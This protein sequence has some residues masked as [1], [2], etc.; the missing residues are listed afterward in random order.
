[1]RILSTL[2]IKRSVKFF[3]TTILLGF[4]LPG[5][6]YAQATGDFRSLATG[7]WNANTTWQRYSGLAWVAAAVGETP[8][9]SSAVLIRDGHTVTVST[10]TGF[11]CGNLTVGEGTSGILSIGGF[12]MT[13]TGT[14][15]IA[16]GGRINVTSATGT[17]K[18]FTGNFTNNGIWN[19]SGNSTITFTG[20]ITN[21]GTFT[22][23]SGAYSLSGL[24]K[25]INSTNA[26]GLTIPSITW[27][28]SYTISSGFTVA[29][30]FASTGITMSNAASS[31]TNNGVVTVSTLTLSNAAAAV[32]NAGTLTP[33]TLTI[34]SAGATVTNTGTVTCGTM[35][36]SATGVFNNN[37]GGTLNYSGSTIT[38]ILNASTNANL[39][40]YTA[41]GTQTVKGTTYHNLTI[42]GSG[43]KTLGAATQ[44][45]K[46]LIVSGTA[47]LADGAFAITGNATGTFQLGSG[48]GYTTTRTA[49]NWFVTNTPLANYTIDNNSTVTF[50]ASSTFTLVNNIPSTY[51]HLIFSG[52]GTKTL[53]ASFPITV[54]GNLTITTG[55]MAD[56]GNTITV[57]GNIASTGNQQGAGKVLLTGGAAAHGMQ[58]SGWNNVELDDAQGATLTAALTIGTQTTGTFALTNGVV[59]MNNFNFTINNVN[60]AGFS[61]GSSVAAMV[62]HN[63]TGNFIRQITN[64]TFPTTYLFPLGE[65]LTEYS[66]VSVTINSNTTI[67]NMAFRVVDAQHP[68]DV[69]TTN[70]ASRY[71]TVVSAPA[72][73]NYSASFGYTGAD[74]VGTESS[75]DVFVFDG[76]NWEY[77]P[78][79]AASN[80]VTYDGTASTFATNDAFVVKAPTTFSSTVTID[81]VGGS[82]GVY[83][84]LTGATGLFAALNQGVLS[85]NLT[86][87][88]TATGNITEPGTIALNQVNE[89]GA[90]AGTY[91]ITIQSN[92]STQKV[93]DGNYT[94]AAIAS[95]GLIRLNGAD[96][97]T[98]NGGTGT[99]R[100]LLFRNNSAG[101]FASVFHFLN[102][103]S[104]NKINNCTVEGS[105]AGNITSAI[106]GLIYVGAGVTT[107]NDNI[108]ITRNDIKQAGSTTPSNGVSSDGTSA[109]VQNNLGEI[110]YNN[111][112]NIHRG[113]TDNAAIHIAGNSPAW[114]IKNNKIYQESART[115]VTSTNYGIYFSTTTS[116]GTL[117]DNNV[118]GYATAGGTGNISFNTL[119]LN[120][121]ARF[122][123]IYL[124]GSGTGALN[125]ITNNI[126]DNISLTTTS[127]GSAT[128]PVF[129]GIFLNGGKYLVDGNYIG[130]TSGV[131]SA[132]NGINIVTTTNNTTSTS[133]AAIIANTTSTSQ[134]ISNNHIGAVAMALSS[135]TLALNFHG[136]KI[137]TGSV[138]VDRNE[139]GNATANSF[140]LSNPGTGSALNYGIWSASGSSGSIN[141]T[142]NVVQNVAAINT[143]ASTTSQAVGIYASGV[144]TYA[145]DGNEIK[146]I[147]GNSSITSATTPS[148]VGITAT[149]STILSHSISGNTIYA[150]SNTS[151]ANTVVT[152]IYFTGNNANSQINKNFIYNLRS[153]LGVSSVINGIHIGSST[154]ATVSNNRVRLGLDELGA[155]ILNTPI[156]T[157]IL[158]DN[159]SANNIYYNSVYIGGSGVNATANN[160]YA[161]RRLLAGSTDNF[162]NNI[163]V[164]ARSN[165]AGGGKHYGL[166]LI[167]TATLTEDYNLIYT[168]GTGGVLASVNG[169]D[170]TTMTAW[171]AANSGLDVNSVS[172]DPQFEDPTNATAPNLKLK[173]NVATP[174]ES[175]AIA[176]SGLF[177]DFEATNVRTGY[178]LGLP[179]GG[180]APDMGADEANLIPKDL[181]P[182]VIVLT[183]VSNISA[184]CGASQTI[185]VTATV[186]DPSGVASGSLAPTLWWRVSTGTYASLLPSS[187]SGTTYTYTLNLTGVASGQ[188][189]H[190]YI[191]AQDLVSPANIG[192][193]SGAP[194]HTDVSATPSP[195]NSSPATFT[196]VSTTP[197]SG[198]VNVGAGQTYTTLTGAGGL[199]AAINTNG[200]SGNLTANITSDI[201]TENG[202]NSLNQITNYCGGPYTVTITPSAA[203][204]RT[205]SGTLL[206]A[207]INLNGADNVTF[208]GRFNGTGTT[209]YLTIANTRA[210][211][212]GNATIRFMNDAQDNTV[213]YCTVTGNNQGYLSGVITLGNAATGGTGNS[214]NTID[215]CSITDQSNARHVTVGIFSNNTTAGTTNSTMA[216]G[217]TI[218]NNNIYNI[219]SF[220]ESDVVGVYVTGSGN[221]PNWNISGNNFYSPVNYDNSQ[222]SILFEAG[223][224]SHSNRINNNLIGGNAAPVA[225]VIQGTWTNLCDAFYRT[226]VNP[227]FIQT[228]GSSMAQ[229]TEVSNNTIQNITMAYNSVVQVTFVGIQTS[230]GYFNIHH[231]TVG[232]N[233]TT[234]NIYNRGTQN[235]STGFVWDMSFSYGIWNT[236][237]DEAII[238]N[239]TV[240]GFTLDN[241]ASYACGIRVGATEFTPAS[242]DITAGKNTITNNVVGDLFSAS[243]SQNFA[244]PGAAVGIMCYSKSNNNVVESNRIVNISA[245]GNSAA[246]VRSMGMAIEGDAALGTGGGSVS[247]NTIYL[248]PNNNTGAS[249]TFNPQAY[250]IL[251]GFINTPSSQS[252]Y[253]FSNNMI[254]MLNTGTNDLSVVGIRD[255][256]GPGSV[257]NYYSN[258]IR[259]SGNNAA[260]GVNSSSCFYSDNAI[261]Q[262]HRNNIYFNNRRGAN[263]NHR[264]ITIGS[265]LGGGSS[266]YNFFATPVTSVVGLYNGGS[267]TGFTTWKS[268]TG[269]DANSLYAQVT[270]ATNFSTNPAVATVDSN[271]GKFF[272]L[273]YNTSAGNFLHIDVTDGVSNQFVSNKG[274]LTGT[275]I[276]DDFDGGARTGTPDIGADEFF[277]CT[278]PVV[279]GNTPTNPTCAGNDGSI[280]LSG[281][282]ASTSFTVTYDKNST[283]VA[284]ASYT[285]NGS[286]VIT[287]SG[288]GNGNYNNFVITAGPGCSS[289]AYPSSGSVTLTNPVT[290]VVSSN[291]PTNPTCVGGDGTIA[292][293]GL[294][295][296]TTYSV[297]YSKNGSPVAAANFTSNG[298]GVVTIGSLTNGAYTNFVLT[299]VGGCAS[300]AYPSSGSITLTAPACGTNTWQGDVVG[301]ATDWFDAGNW[302]SNVVP[303]SCSADAVIPTSPSGGNNFPILTASASVGNITVFDNASI[304]INSGRSLAVCGNWTGGTTTAS[305]V[306]GA[307]NVVLTGNAAQTLNGRTAFTT[308]H[309]GKTTGTTATMQA[310][311]FFDINTAVELESGTLATGS[312]TLTFKSTSTTQ[313]AVLDN[314]TTGYTGNLTG[315]ITAERYY[316]T[317][318]VTNQHYMGSPVA[319]TLSQFGAGSSSGFVTPKPTCDETAL[320][321]TSVYGS[322]FSYDQSNGSSCSLAGW[323]VEAG[324]TA[325]TAAKGFSVTKTGSNVLSVSGAP[326]LTS[327]YSQAGTNAGWSNSSLQGRPM[328]AGWVLV[329]NPYLAYLDFT[330]QGAPTNFTNEVK[331]WHTTGAFAGSYQDLQAGQMI[332]PFQGFFVHSTATGSYPI[333]GNK[334]TRSTAGTFQAQANDQQLSITA[335]NTATGLA[336][337][338]MVAFNSDAT[339]GFDNDY[340]AQ[341]I[342]GTLGRHTL[343]TVGANNLWMSKN[344]HKSIAE[345][346][347]ITM[348]FEPGTGGSYT[349]SFDGLNSFDPTSYIMLEDRKLGTMYNVRNGDYQFTS[350]TA[351]QWER[352][353]LHFTPAAEITTVNEN[354]STLG[355]INVNQPGTANWNYTIAD[356][357]NNNAVVATGTLNETTPISVAVSGSTYSITLVDTN[358]YTVVK[359][360]TVTGIT[361]I[362]AAFTS[363]ATTVE[364]GNDVTFNSTTAA[365]VTTEWNF[366]DGT[367][368]NTNYPNPTHTYSTPGTYTVTLTVTNRDGCT[369][370]TTQ[371][372]TVTE[373]VETGIVNINN[374]SGINIWSHSNQV[375]IDFS[376]L[377]KTDVTVS[378]Y[379]LLGQELVN[380][381]YGRSTIY[382]K[383]ILNVEASYVI[384]KVTNGDTI[385]TK[386]VFIANTK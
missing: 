377:A 134:T 283:P 384:V 284:S 29:K 10:G 140:L 159:T 262:N 119:V 31:M 12:A 213:K 101:S 105:Q 46:D 302:S 121:A 376:K 239:N 8:T 355:N 278:T 48:T 286:G 253:T 234:N 313:I 90:G 107:G 344:I 298:S 258:T 382:S 118:I 153:G 155:A 186:S 18:F 275:G 131:A 58:G 146:G 104:D 115:G 333:N 296:G 43:T 39:V 371:T 150:L 320:A 183:P 277:I 96:R 166:Y 241:T 37:N 268:N 362:N 126:I 217:N 194:G 240:A 349:F 148:V 81:G 251:T 282:A 215:N 225:G 342:A 345:T 330:T 276:T 339:T 50:G 98:F 154:V 34:S 228:G 141:I 99:D 353:V 224:S 168:P 204:L 188:T 363:S 151:A 318:G 256:N 289:A 351:D 303:N 336:D 106:Q 64:S 112:Y 23:G 15:T 181:L 304:T 212:S 288:L 173:T 347:T 5:M 236:S 49:T 192:Y 273:P 310:G 232:K 38:P 35:N 165:A 265:T 54:N 87:N 281:L 67:G 65:S 197:L 243:S 144:S 327:S 86:V 145:I 299:P 216:K 341:K 378:I 152:G 89:T 32:S 297:T 142:N 231:N 334:R 123:G 207:L 70:Y 311:S 196:V 84:N 91:T 14:T 321:S 156:I 209:S 75:F 71:W 368:D 163:F 176:I 72:T 174:A 2:S 201:T 249:S 83:A 60:A 175:G 88:V 80:V 356:I 245:Y 329:S 280:A 226:V 272:V 33:T 128:V 193:S 28:G 51:G 247:K 79:T 53:P 305:T 364:E 255:M 169:T 44:V 26:S 52:S 4:L 56:N 110:S 42:S 218:T 200:L 219:H 238:D 3:V 266:D 287:I 291:T 1:M 375:M 190:Y 274:N 264:A 354:C 55:N 21:N 178:P 189:Y 27:L 143:L 187:V 77:N 129:S 66:P 185:T 380:E 379:N 182:P 171:K 227:I 294:A 373:K 279:S 343:Y 267:S 369:S 137:V 92:N 237:S 315:N 220:E 335:A 161:F 360:V 195:I 208:D 16:S 162:R 120:G 63:G 357:N 7:N 259:I 317:T 372:V 308:L 180:T 95:N 370:T 260:S 179:Q 261:T 324:S 257:Q 113:T 25:N 352:F 322:V 160:T 374:K 358:N 223:A 229:A 316:S 130:A 11:A 139:I 300:T 109:T 127:G 337:L 198:I 221:G 340:D 244:F 85:G 114:T 301:N 350:D 385:T 69:N 383:A 202:A 323:K 103:A 203:T 248:I 271:A 233:G 61:G 74:I 82:A 312:G 210:T 386:K 73:F 177:D 167:S 62:L 164:N 136:I 97:V 76:T 293:S 331:I 78:A 125:T 205:V 45:N 367:V 68:N 348:G 366:G 36:G 172:G 290:P 122:E 108:V 19:N 263:S 381:K 22:A 30:P 319:T 246:N 124:N 149:V 306:T 211:A 20:D 138:T 235:G 102:D 191:A 6:I 222:F 359:M 199:F 57:K 326:N 292:L 184:S 93:F 116:N 365:A 111:I 307:G 24:S 332:A 41:S 147:T 135:G 47:T 157:G 285:S 100:R 314:F 94:G 9:S 309:V 17:P 242:S 158:K 230:T 269:G 206:G 170:Q 13:V 133:P 325:A 214:G 250:G 346:S 361:P 117:I 59:N 295:N 338:T 270:A 40:N 254:S 328:T 132:T 252:F